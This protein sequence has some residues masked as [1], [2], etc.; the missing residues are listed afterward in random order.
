MFAEAFKQSYGVTRNAFL[1][2]SNMIS[3]SILD[4]TIYTCIVA[5][6]MAIAFSI[7]ALCFSSQLI[8]DNDMMSKYTHEEPNRTIQESS[9]KGKRRGQTLTTIQDVGKKVKQL[10]HE[11]Q[12]RQETGSQDENLTSL[13]AE[14]QTIQS[15]LQQMKDMR[16]SD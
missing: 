16:A 1:L 2:S 15:E 6:V 14:L 11:I 9:S 8:S 7:P 10:L 4:A 13:K 5:L 3:F 12:L